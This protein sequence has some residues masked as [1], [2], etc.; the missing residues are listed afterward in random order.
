MI[1]TKSAVFPILPFILLLVCLLCVINLYLGF[2]QNKKDAFGNVVNA[3]MC[4][5]FLNAAYVWVIECF[6]IKQAWLNPMFPFIF[7]YGPFYYFGLST[8]KGIELSFKTLLIHTIPFLGF[9]LVFII[10]VFNDWHKDQLKYESYTNYKLGLAVLSLMVYCFYGFQ[11]KINSAVK[12]NDQRIIML[13]SRVMLFFLF[14]IHLAVFISGKLVVQTEQ[15]F[16]SCR[17]L[18]YCCMLVVTALIFVYQTVPRLSP[19]SPEQDKDPMSLNM[20]EP[21]AKYKKSVLNELQLDTYEVILKEAMKHRELFLNQELSL[22]ELA[23]EIKIPSHHLTQLLSTRF[24]LT[25]HHYINHS[26]VL[27]ACRLME[28]PSGRKMTLEELGSLS[29]FNSKVSFNR[30]FKLWTGR[31]PSEFRKDLI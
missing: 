29:G 23:L 11:S 9:L 3:L 13:F 16:Y 7:L 24:Q 15:S 26:R 4:F 14:L 1:A 18:I 10:F 17:I 20:K 31:T 6:F 27:Y 5:L 21:I 22:N 25:F 19:G 12:L 30:H 28:T 2:K 8:L